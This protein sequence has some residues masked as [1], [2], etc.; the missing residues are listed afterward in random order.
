ML[1]SWFWVAGKKG[2]RAVEVCEGEGKKH[3]RMYRVVKCA[4][5]FL[6]ETAEFDEAELGEPIGLQELLLFE[7]EEEEV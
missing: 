5:R 7:I 2:Q 1:D 6:G 4:L 3:F